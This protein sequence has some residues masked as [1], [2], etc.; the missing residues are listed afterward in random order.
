MTVV[1]HDACLSEKSQRHW[2]ACRKH[3]RPKR[4]AALRIYE[5]H[6]GMSS[7]EESVASYTFFKGGHPNLRPQL[8]DH[9]HS[10]CMRPMEAQLHTK[11]GGCCTQFALLL[12]IC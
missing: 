7:E 3:E 1:I 12:Q 11:S 10:H 9:L 6:V 5:A 2:I 8:A 4:P